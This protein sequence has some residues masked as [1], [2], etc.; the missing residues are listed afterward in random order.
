MIPECPA[1]EICRKKKVNCDVC[2]ALS[3]EAWREHVWKVLKK[4]WRAKG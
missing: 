2:Q 4:K 1:Y 3:I